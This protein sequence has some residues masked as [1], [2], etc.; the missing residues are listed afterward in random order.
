MFCPSTWGQASN[1]NWT[2]WNCEPEWIFPLFFFFF[3]STWVW[4]QGLTVARQELY[5]LNHSTNPFLL[6]SCLYQVYCHSNEKE[7]NT[8]VFPRYNTLNK[9][10]YLTMNTNYLLL[11]FITE[12]LR[13]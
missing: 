13:Q 10:S 9:W 2:F 8:M 6:L 5:H 12:I 11:N 4:T 1:H 7:S 3:G